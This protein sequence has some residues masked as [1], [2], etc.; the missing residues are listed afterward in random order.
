MTGI[1][2]TIR[3]TATMVAAANKDAM[4]VWERQ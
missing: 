3:R 2:A 1:P 4:L